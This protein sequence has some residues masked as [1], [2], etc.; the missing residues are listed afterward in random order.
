MRS[1]A[2]LGAH[3]DARRGVWTSFN[4]EAEEKAW[5]ADAKRQQQRQAQRDWLYIDHSGYLNIQD[6]NGEVHRIAYDYYRVLRRG[7]HAA[8]TSM[9]RYIVQYHTLNGRWIGVPADK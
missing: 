8:K 6:E 7:G 1:L 5:V 9:G 2:E 4:N 3:Y